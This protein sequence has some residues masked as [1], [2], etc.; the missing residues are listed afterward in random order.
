MR[1][2]ALSLMIAWSRSAIARSDSGMSAILP[3]MSLSPSA[4]SASGSTFPRRDT[5]L[6]SLALSCIAARSSSVQTLPDFPRSL[7]LFASAIALIPL[8]C[9][10]GGCLLGDLSLLED[11]DGVAERIAQA[12]VGPVEMV[13]GLLG[14]IGHAA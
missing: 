8:G 3:R 4:R 9:R 14:E 2:G 5:A 7:V 6:R 1:T 10:S 11:P 12:H 13:G